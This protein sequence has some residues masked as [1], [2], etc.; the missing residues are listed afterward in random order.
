MTG[1]HDK[2]TLSAMLAPGPK[3]HAMHKT[4]L[5]ETYRLASREEDLAWIAA[6]SA[7][8]FI[9]ELADEWCDRLTERREALERAHVGRRASDR[10]LAA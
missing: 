7:K 5:L 3:S 4:I 2:P 6:H 8:P 10:R 1:I 9:R